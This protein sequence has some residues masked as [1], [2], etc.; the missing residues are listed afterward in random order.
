MVQEL[1]AILEQLGCI[2][3]R[4]ILAFELLGQDVVHIEDIHIGNW[5]VDIGG[6][7]LPPT[8]VALARLKVIQ[9][10]PEVARLGR[11]GHDDVEID[12]GMV[13]AETAYRLEKTNS[14]RE[15][16]LGWA[17]KTARKLGAQA[18]WN[19]GHAHRSAERLRIAES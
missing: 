7:D 5:A 4:D 11:V 1:A 13:E 14:P 15:I 9:E 12:L 17:N 8:E 6:R 10:L 2:V 16:D 18:S 3:W 19:A